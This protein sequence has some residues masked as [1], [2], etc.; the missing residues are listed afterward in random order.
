MLVC[1][2][3][4][5]KAGSFYPKQAEM[6]KATYL[7]NYNQ[8]CIRHGTIQKENGV[9]IFLPNDSTKKITIPKNKLLNIEEV[10]ELE[11]I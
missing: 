7:N 4:Y 3:F 6:I 9:I 10:F 1:S 11:I 2:P 5:R 8:E